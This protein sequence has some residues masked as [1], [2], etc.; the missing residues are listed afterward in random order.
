ML[1]AKVTVI[2]DSV[3]LIDWPVWL[4]ALLRPD[5]MLLAVFWFAKTP[6]GMVTRIAMEKPSAMITS[7]ARIFLREIFLIAL[8]ITPM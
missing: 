1:D 7:K 5:V 3:W 6:A 4:M 2:W 8:L